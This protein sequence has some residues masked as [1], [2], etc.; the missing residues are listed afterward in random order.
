MNFAFLAVKK[1]V[2][3]N[4]QIPGLASRKAKKKIQAECYPLKKKLSDHLGRSNGV[5]LN[6]R[7]SITGSFIR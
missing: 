4:L 1:K 6:R 7:G 2:L 5:G 3:V